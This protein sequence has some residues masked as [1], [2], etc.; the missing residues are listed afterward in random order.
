M[1]SVIVPLPRSGD[2]ISD[3]AVR[4]GDVARH[5]GEGETAVHA[6]RGIDLDDE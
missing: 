3:V 2:T 5:Y 1:T 6:L 4:A